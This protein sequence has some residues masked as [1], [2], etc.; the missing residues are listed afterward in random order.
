MW[1][2]TWKELAQLYEFDCTFSEE[3][4]NTIIISSMNESKGTQRIKVIGKYLTN[5]R[6]TEM[7][8]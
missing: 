4:N 3:L 5:K 6:V 8:R 1:V 2:S 7:A